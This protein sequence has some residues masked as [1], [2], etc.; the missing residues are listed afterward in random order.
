MN[1]FV[2]IIVSILTAYLAFTNTLAGH[3][4]NFLDSLSSEPEETIEAET[5]SMVLLPSIFGNSIPDILLRSSD[6]QAAALATAISGT[7][8]N[9]NAV[10]TLDTAFVNDPPTLAGYGGDALALRR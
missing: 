6:Y 7:S 5:D 2:E 8:N 9:T 1:I 4:G 3:I 10:P